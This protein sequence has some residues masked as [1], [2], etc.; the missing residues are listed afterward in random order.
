M[1][2]VSFIILSLSGPRIV[3]LVSNIHHKYVDL[4]NMVDTAPVP[5]HLC[6]L[7]DIGDNENF[8][9]TIVEIVIF[10]IMNTITM[11]DLLNLSI[12]NKHVFIKFYELSQF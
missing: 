6:A 8:T 4:G 1:H 12:H 11:M 10:M 2:P 3:Q 9:I 7:N 5:L